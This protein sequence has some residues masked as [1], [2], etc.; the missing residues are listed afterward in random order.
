MHGSLPNAMVMCAQ[1]SR[2]HINNNPW[3]AIPPLPEL[4]RMHEMLV[5]HLRPA[6]VIAV[7]LNTYDL[8]VRAARSAIEKTRKL[9]GL[10]TTD[11]VRFDP[12]PVVEAIDAFHRKRVRALARKADAPHA[13][14]RTKA[15]AKRK[16]IANGR[17]RPRWRA[18]WNGVS[19]VWS[20]PHTPAVPRMARRRALSRPSTCESGTSWRAHLRRWPNAARK[21]HWSR[22]D[23]RSA[24]SRRAGRMRDASK[25]VIPW[26]RSPLV[27]M[28]RTS[29]RRPV[30]ARASSVCGA[31][32]A[33]A[34][35]VA[36]CCSCSDRCGHAGRRRVRGSGWWNGAVD[37]AAGW[38]SA[39]QYVTKG[40]VAIFN[41]KRIVS[42]P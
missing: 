38:Q 20:P 37:G 34:S 9:T 5:Q 41:R 18:R 27:G 32:Y 10:P 22:I 1:P 42:S 30:G 7:A 3:I 12:E 17:A 15:A 16:R 35:H 11:A 19:G 8:S 6:P 24:L 4:I 25:R 2:T 33:G 14:K 21:A 23:R 26:W 40:T 29:S 13:A 28:A 39:V 36:L 31:I